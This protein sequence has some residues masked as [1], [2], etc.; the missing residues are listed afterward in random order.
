MVEKLEYDLFYE[1]EM[2][3]RGLGGARSADSWETL[4][5]MRHHGVP[6]RLIDWTETFGVAIHF[7]LAAS[8]ATDAPGIWLL[9]P[10]KLNQ[11]LGERDLYAPDRLTA[12]DGTR[13]N[14][15]AIITANAIRFGFGT[16]LA[17]YPQHSNAR[18]RAQGGYFTLH[19]DDWRPLEESAPDC[20]SFVPLP[21]TARK[22]AAEFL[23]QSG[24][25]EFTLFPD[26]DGL[27]RFLNKKYALGG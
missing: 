4:F 23:Q 3:V 13:M 21:S 10:Y 9:N 12:A 18:L 11:R 2:R 8:R 17:L 5:M 19:G 24:I 22:A 7:A 27:A 15:D 25:N 20:V 16:P 6:C 1:F 26:P 14:Y